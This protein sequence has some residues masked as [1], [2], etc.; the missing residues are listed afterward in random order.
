MNAHIDNKKMMY[1]VIGNDGNVIMIDDPTIIK[2]IE[3]AQKA[4]SKRQL[5]KQKKMQYAG[6]KSGK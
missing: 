3:D 4:P 2:A 5:K 6:I 1:G